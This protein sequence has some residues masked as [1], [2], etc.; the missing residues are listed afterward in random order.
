M[1]LPDSHKIS[2][3]PW[4]LGTSNRKAVLF[5]VHGC[6]I[7]WHHFPEVSARRRF[8]NFPAGSQPRP[9]TSHNPEY[10]TVATLTCI[11]FRLVPVRSPLLRKSQLLYFPGGT[12]MFQFPP[13]ASTGLCIQP[14]IPQVYLRWV[15]PFGNS[16]ITA[17]L[18]LPE[19]DRSLPRP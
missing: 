6:H 11:R 14:G 18:Q 3:V 10:T 16:R 17:C 2:R 15:P 5:C 12:E 4:Y 13:F 8:G 19:T 9:S 1:V 7:L